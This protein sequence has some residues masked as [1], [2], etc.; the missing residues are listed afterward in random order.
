MER[1]VF[2][3]IDDFGLLTSV[4]TYRELLLHQT[5]FTVNVV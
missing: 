4:D 2:I 1:F 5:D 3:L